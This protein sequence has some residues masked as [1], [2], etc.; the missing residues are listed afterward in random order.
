MSKEYAKKWRAERK[1]KGLCR[2]CDKKVGPVSR[3]LCEECRKKTNQRRI[4]KKEAGLCR[5]CNEPVNEK[6]TIHCDKCLPIFQAYRKKYDKIHL[7][8]FAIRNRAKKHGIAFLIDLETFV[9]WHSES[10]KLCHYCGVSENELG[11]TGRKKNM[12]TVDRKNNRIGY[13]LSNL[14]LACFRCNNMKSNFFTEEEWKEV[15]DKFIKPRLGEYHTR[16]A[17]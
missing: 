2:Y 16:Y 4:E 11:R 9:Q 8:F 5:R 13:E 15:A 6:S 10:P 3:I 12:L 7:R 17:T 1:A 14:C